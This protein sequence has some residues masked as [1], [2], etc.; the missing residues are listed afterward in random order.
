MVILIDVGQGDCLLIRAEGR[1]YLSDCGSTDI[2]QVFRYRVAPFLKH[3]GIT[4]LD[5]VFL[6]HADADHINGISEYL[7]DEGL[8]WLTIGRLYLTE[9]ETEKAEIRDILRLAEEQKIP[10][11]YLQRGDLLLPGSMKFRILH[12]EEGYRGNSDN[13]ES[14]TFLL[15]GRGFRM[16]FTGDLDFEGE[17]QLLRQQLGHVNVLKAAHHGSNGATGSELLKRVTP[18]QVVVSCGVN[19]MYHHPGREFAAR[20]RKAG[21]NPA[22]TSECGAIT[23]SWRNNRLELDKYLNCD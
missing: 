8:H 15:E 16:L 1:N 20:V 22:I 10:A 12:P 11:G 4:R 7:S 5:G 17:E 2:K 3:E 21:I 19:N 23:I 9:Q 14:L 6:S 13:A 18:E